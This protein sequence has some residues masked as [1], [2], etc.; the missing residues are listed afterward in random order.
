MVYDR[1]TSKFCGVMAK[2]EAK[3]QSGVTDKDKV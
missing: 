1:E 2:I 3:N